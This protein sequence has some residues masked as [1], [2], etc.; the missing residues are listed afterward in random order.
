M[1]LLF[2]GLKSLVLVVGRAALLTNSKRMAILIGQRID[3]GW[4]SEELRAR[5]DKSMGDGFAKHLLDIKAYTDSALAGLEGQL[6]RDILEPGVLAEYRLV[7]QRIEETMRL[8]TPWLENPNSLTAERELVRVYKRNDPVG[9][10]HWLHNRL[11][12]SGVGETLT[13]DIVTKC[14]RDWGQ[15]LVWQQQICLRLSQACILELAILKI[16]GMYC[17]DL[18]KSFDV[19]VAINFSN[20]RAEFSFF[21]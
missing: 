3:T 5:L 21:A 4:T 15:F 6:K 9:A 20:D 18:R 8:L 17:T 16:N 7:E 13:D 14:G 11:T 1:E 19:Y 12:N 2:G 10:V